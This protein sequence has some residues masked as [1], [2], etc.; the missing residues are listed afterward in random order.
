[1]NFIGIKQILVIIFILKIDFY[2]FFLYFLFTELRLLLAENT[3]T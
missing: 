3:G 1:M 2:F